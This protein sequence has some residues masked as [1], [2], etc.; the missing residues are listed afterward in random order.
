MDCRRKMLSRS[1]NLFN[2][3]PLPFQPT[4]HK[5]HLDT[6]THTTIDYICV[7]DSSKII[8]TSQIHC[9]SISTHDAVCASFEFQVSQQH[10][11][12]VFKRSFR[13][14]DTA[15]FQS[16]LES[17]DWHAIVP[18]TNIDDKINFLSRSILQFYDRHAPYHEVVCR[19]KFA[20]WFSAELRQLIKRRN[21]AW[22]KYKKSRQNGDHQAYKTL[23]N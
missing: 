4:N 8:S 11:K 1:L 16:D 22:S 5:K 7:S 23:R 21:R 20:R 10:P 9:P 17:I 12:K 14:F 2:L 13:Q 19:K 15:L 3:E 6:F 18:M